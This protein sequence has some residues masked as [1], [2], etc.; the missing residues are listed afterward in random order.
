MN[1]INIPE[2][3]SLF[4]DHWNPRII[5]ELNGQHVKLGKFRGEF[6]WHKHDIED[7][8]FYVLEGE[9]TMEFRDRTVELKKGDMLIVPKGVEHRPVAEHEVSVMLFEP[10]STL[11]TGNTRGELTRDSLEQI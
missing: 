9:F 4:T 1:K 6:V 11:N 5:G 2:K 8:L 7:E 10:M 3:L